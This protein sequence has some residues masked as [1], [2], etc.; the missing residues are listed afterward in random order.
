MTPIAQFIDLLEKNHGPVARRIDVEIDPETG[1]KL[2]C[3]EKNNLTQEQIKA[4]RGSGNTWSLALK[5]C[6]GLVC[7]DFDQK[8][9]ENSKL[10]ALLVERDCL[11]VETTKGWH[12]YVRTDALDNCKEIGV[13]G[14]FK[15][16][17][18]TGK[19][20]VWETADRVLTG[21]LID[22]PWVYLEEHLD[23][24]ASVKRKRASVVES[25]AGVP[26]EIEHWLTDKFTVGRVILPVLRYRYWYLPVILL[27]RCRH[28]SLLKS[29][30]AR[31][32]RLAPPAVAVEARWRRWQ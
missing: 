1:R 12:I 22:V 23:F 11:R 20:N 31:A 25:E 15:V 3:G 8:D 19:R 9:L 17:L 2:C 30:Q 27:A 10:F 7:V 24:T 4:N 6:P 32:T 29:P 28:Q 18:L 14:D 26:A 16:D 21:E 5:H 13:G